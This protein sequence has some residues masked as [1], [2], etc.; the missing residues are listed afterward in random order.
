[1]T[2][3]RCIS[4]DVRYEDGSREYTTSAEQAEEIWSWLM[5]AQALN[6]IHGARYTGRKFDREDAPPKTG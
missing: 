1:M 3:P 4:I 5:G 6:C 2:E